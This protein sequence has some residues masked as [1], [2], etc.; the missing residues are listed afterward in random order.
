MSANRA[1]LSSKPVQPQLNRRSLT[2]SRAISLFVVGASLLLAG[3]STATLRSITVSPAAGTEVLTGAGQS[4]QYKALGSYVQGSHPA[5]IRDVTNAVQWTSGNTQVATV[6]ATG[7]VTSVGPGNAIITATDGSISAS[8]DVTVNV[9]A[10]PSRALTSITILPGSQ[11]VGNIGETTQY[12]A[13]GSYTGGTPVTQ[14]LTDLVKWS[15]S[16][17]FVAT[18]DAAGL[19]TTVSGGPTTITALYTPLPTASNPNPATITATAQLNSGSNMGTVTLPTLTLYKV[20]TNAQLGTVTATY[21]LPGTS[22]PVTFTTCGP[23]ATTVQCT[24]NV[25]VGVTVTLTTPNTGTSPLFGGW[26]SN[27]TVVSGNP[28]SCTITLTAPNPQ[29]NTIGNVAVGAIFD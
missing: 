2:F 8:S 5:D 18:I 3:C 9:T 11:L 19:A 10:T 15:S 17:V 23:N 29:T 14:D 27:C 22:T 24:T 4:F 26:S 1:Y 6:N 12:I 20:G 7:A 13:I 21:I 28:Y 16:D 25:P